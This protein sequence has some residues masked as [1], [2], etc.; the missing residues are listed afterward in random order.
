M[1]EF[2]IHISGLWHFNCAIQ[3]KSEH[4]AKIKAFQEALKKMDLIEL[5]PKRH[6]LDG[7]KRGQL[8]EAE[9]SIWKGYP[10]DPIFNRCDK[11]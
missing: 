3:A 5:V 10:L 6:W 1:K 11:Q 4:D 8:V 2:N 7:Q 9:C